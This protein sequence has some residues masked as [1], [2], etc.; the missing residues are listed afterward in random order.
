[1]NTIKNAYYNLV[2]RAS[3]ALAPV[4]GMLPGVVHADGGTDLSNISID[5]T[6]KLTGVDT[7]GSGLTGGFLTIL[8]QMHVA[9]SGVTAVGAAILVVIFIIKVIGL[10]KSSDNANERSRSIMGLIV[11][12]V[13]AALLGS[14]SLIT[15]MF[16]GAFS[17]IGG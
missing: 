2:S 14:A 12:A 9:I 4:A 10:A 17:G 3:L 6:G 8:D 13:C 11:I 1:M 15:G 16:W 5:S 7:S